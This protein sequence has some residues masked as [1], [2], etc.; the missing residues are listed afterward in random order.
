[1][2]H[3]LLLQAWEYLQSGGG[4][5]VPLLLVSL[6]MWGLILQ[7][8]L[9]LHC[10]QRREWSLQDCL[11]ASPER[12]A[13]TADWQQAL[14]RLHHQRQQGHLGGTGATMQG[15]RQQQQ[16]RVDR[17][18]KTILVLSGVAPL[19]GLLGTVMGMITTFEVIQEFGTG[20]ARAMAG[21]ISEALVTTQAGLVIAVPG[22]VLGKL[23]QRH[24]QKIKARMHIFCLGLQREER[25]S[26]PAT[27]RAAGGEKGAGHD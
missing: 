8:T 22:M 20:N 6:V 27:S 10:W 1:M 23:L 3:K 14:L 15:V 2:E 4:I 26:Q 7:K 9:E 25:Q 24:A 18:I 13:E 11:H 19:L 21:G 16:A 17:H 12:W 5:V